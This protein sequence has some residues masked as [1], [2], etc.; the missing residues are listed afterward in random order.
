MPCCCNREEDSNA[1]DYAGND[2][3]EEES[4]EEQDSFDADLYGDLPTPSEDED[5]EGGVDGEY[6][7]DG[8]GEYG[9]DDM[10]P[11]DAPTFS[12]LY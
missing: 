3:P 4:D 9:D 12:M 8:G 2:Y 7:D 11:G 5:D 10:E 6:D 1:E